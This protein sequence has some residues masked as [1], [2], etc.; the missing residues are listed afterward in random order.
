MDKVIKE[1]GLWYIKEEAQNIKDP[2]MALIYWEM[3]FIFYFSE[4]GGKSFP[5]SNYFNIPLDTLPQSAQASLTK[6]F[7]GVISG[8]RSLD[9]AL[10]AIYYS[11]N[12]W[13]D[14]ILLYQ[15]L[16]CRHKYS[17]ILRSEA[18]RIFSSS[19]AWEALSKALPS[20]LY[21][22]V[23]TPAVPAGQQAQQQYMADFEYVNNLS[24][25]IGD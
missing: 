17:L 1:T 25:G 11:F 7:N 19:V 24:A 20:P 5:L 18:G 22:W 21:T 4:A 2:A 6:Y 3:F 13:R 14:S 23:R 10:V 15:C 16:E 9:Q 8:S 12:T